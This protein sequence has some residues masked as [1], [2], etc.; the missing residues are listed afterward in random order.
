MDEKVDIL[1]KSA[2]E[3]FARNKTKK[4][5][6]EVCEIAEKNLNADQI[7]LFLTNCDDDGKNF[8]YHFSRTTDDEALQVSLFK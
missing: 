6:V 1:T 2:L 8:L 3:L 5:F 4:F 7:K